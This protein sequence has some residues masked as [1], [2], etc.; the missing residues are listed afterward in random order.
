MEPA[1]F[2]AAEVWIHRKRIGELFHVE[3]SAHGLVL[4]GQE[5]RLVA[6]HDVSAHVSTEAALE[7]SR[8]RFQELVENLSEVVLEVNTDATITYISPVVESLLGWRP[9]QLVGQSILELVAP[10]FHELIV[11][12]VGEV[13]TTGES[14][15]VDYQ[16]VTSAGGRAW[17]R[18]QSRPI[19][20]G[21]EIVGFHAAVA[22]VTALKE[23]EERLRGTQEQL[24]ESQKMEAVGRLAGGIA[25]DFNNL[26]TVIRGHAE[27][28]RETLE[29]A[30]LDTSST[31]EILTAATRAAELTRQMLAFGRRQ[32]LRPEAIDLNDV[33]R[34]IERMLK[35]TLRADIGLETDLDPALD[36][37]FVDAWQV[38]QV[39]LSLAVNSQDAMPRGGRLWIRTTATTLDGPRASRLGLAPGRYVELAV[40]DDGCGIPKDLQDRVF[41]PF[42][43][44]KEVGQGSGLGLST[45]YGI[46]RQ[47]GGAV[48]LESEEGKGTTLRLFLP[49]AVDREVAVDGSAPSVQLAGRTVLVVEDDVAVRQ[50]I[51]QSLAAAGMTVF[52]AGDAASARVL[53]SGNLIRR[54]DLILSDYALPG[55]SGVELAEALLERW[56]GVAVLITTAHAV[57]DLGTDA[58]VFP[59]IEKPFTARRLHESVRSAL[60]PR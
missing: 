45:V 11:A 31:D 56:P 21:G 16:V 2:A 39:L 51:A 3:V 15:L 20:R 28:A 37:V 35:R 26:L 46:L 22:D 41:E 58:D 19:R 59:L 8:R 43:T 30:S 23:T 42:F 13:L 40:V 55:G 53:A 36:L 38:H 14:R 32:V 25:H 52:E 1:G 33:V 5:V 10:E 49:R 24:L 12:R 54:L 27:L 9:E 60:A 4:G 57:A 44:T 17:A 50:V 29:D 47:S 34:E 48:D 6:V 7:E 18:S